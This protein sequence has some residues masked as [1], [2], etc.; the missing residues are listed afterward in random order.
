[1]PGYSPIDN[2]RPVVIVRVTIIGP[3]PDPG[4][5][6]ESD[7]D[8]PRWRPRRRAREL[9]ARPLGLDELD[10]R[11]RDRRLQPVPA[12]AAGPPRRVPDDPRTV[13]QPGALRGPR[14][15]GSRAGRAAA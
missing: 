4:G 15:R 14:R 6:H 7:P 9:P 11:R 10:P 2:Y 5:N 3:A 12:R 1:M 13:R 8:H